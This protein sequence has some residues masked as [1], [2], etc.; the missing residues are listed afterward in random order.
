M[1]DNSHL[2]RLDFPLERTHCGIVMGNGSF[3][4]LIWGKERLHIIVNRADFW[5]HRGGELIVPGTTYKGLV[6]VAQKLGYGEALAKA[7]PRDTFPDK[8]NRIIIYK[9]NCHIPK[10]TLSGLASRLLILAECILRNLLN[11]SLIPPPMVLAA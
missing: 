3:G 6:E 2:F 11:S 7:I 5:D 9:I 10:P 1:R 8:H 4:A